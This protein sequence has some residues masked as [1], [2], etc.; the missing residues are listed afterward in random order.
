MDGLREQLAQAR[1]CIAA[2]RERVAGLRCER[3][4]LQQQ[5][6]DAAPAATAALAHQLA[7]VRPS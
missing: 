4:A 2:E 3:E 6:Q 1:G 5:L 7:E